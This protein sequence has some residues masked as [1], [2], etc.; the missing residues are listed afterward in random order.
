M[1]TM[2]S[3]P[4]PRCCVDTLPSATS[5]NSRSHPSQLLDIY[6]AYSGTVLLSRAP[7]RIRIPGINGA[8]GRTQRLDKSPRARRG[9]VCH[10]DSQPEALSHGSLSSFCTRKRG[11]GCM[12]RITASNWEI[13]GGVCNSRYELPTPL[14]LA[15]PRRL[16]HANSECMARQAPSG[17]EYSFIS[18]SARMHMAL[19]VINGCTG[20][21][22]VAPPSIHLHL[23]H[24]F[25]SP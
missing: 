20:F 21:Q 18:V 22:K 11:R 7:Q 5:R 14:W 24:D 6:C 3:A 16:G 1:W 25:A 9:V 15:G 10:R 23:F 12:D 8:S 13:G 17:L 4:A 2:P 19:D